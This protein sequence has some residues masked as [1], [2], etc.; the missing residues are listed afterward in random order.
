MYV[1]AISRE[2]KVRKISWKWEIVKDSVAEG[3]PWTNWGLWAIVATIEMLILL[4]VL[5]TSQCGNHLHHQ[6]PSPTITMTRGQALSDDLRGAI[7][8]MARSLDVESISQYT[9]CKRRTIE[10]TLSD[11]RK[12]GT[13]VQTRV[14][15]ELWGAKRALGPT[16]VRVRWLFH[17]YF[18]LYS[19]TSVLARPSSFQ[20][21]HLSKWAARASRGTK[22]S[23]NQW[24]NIMEITETEWFYLEKGM[25]IL[26]TC[27]HSLPFT[28]NEF[29]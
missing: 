3:A 28:C 12:K 18:L 15:K 10:R 16:D 2:P 11:Y 21:W 5:V 7:V 14:S 6:L 1:Q 17:P 9:G 24:C 13:A 20:S 27:Y 26:I 4:Y 25:F 19:P 22:G 23:W 29:L 8:N